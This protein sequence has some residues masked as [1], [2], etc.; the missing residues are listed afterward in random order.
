MSASEQHGREG[1]RVGTTRC[2][3]HQ[4]LRILHV[5]RS[6][7]SG[8]RCC[9]GTEDEAKW[10]RECAGLSEAVLLHE[11]AEL[12]LYHHCHLGTEQTQGPGTYG[13][14]DVVLLQCSV[15]ETSRDTHE[16]VLMTHFDI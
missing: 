13:V 5:N 15:M 7:T 6:R 4:R 3:S 2:G 1:V 10:S 16:L 9:S 12:R 14:S 11:S 8:S